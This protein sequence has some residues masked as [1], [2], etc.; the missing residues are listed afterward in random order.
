MIQFNEAQNYLHLKSNVNKVTSLKGCMRTCH[1]DDLGF[2][3]QQII[4]SIATTSQQFKSPELLDEKE[5]IAKT[6]Q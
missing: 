3:Y 6:A 2:L 1:S 5:Q 4:G